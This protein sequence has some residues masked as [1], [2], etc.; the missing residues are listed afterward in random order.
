M[1]QRG[2]YNRG[3]RN[4]VAI[5]A[6]QFLIF[7]GVGTTV[8]WPALNYRWYNDDLHMIREFSHEELLLAWHHTWDFDG[9]ETIGYRPIEVLFNHTRARMFG[10]TMAALRLFIIALL[11]A[12][13]VVIARSA[14]RFGL[15]PAATTLAGVMTLCAKYNSYNLVWMADGVHVWQ[16]LTFALST[17]LRWVD[18]G[19]F[20]WMAAS[21]V[22]FVLG[23]LTH[24]GA[25]GVAP[26]L[27]VLAAVASLNSGKLAGQQKKLLG[28]AGVLAAVSLAALLARQS[29]LTAETDPP[30]TVP[31]YLAAQFV[32]I[33]TLAGWEPN[34]LVAVFLAIFAL[35]LLVAF[36]LTA[37][38]KQ[39]AMV[40][41][42][43]AR[44]SASPGIVETRVNLLLFPITFYCLFAAQV[45]VAYATGARRI[46]SLGR[47]IAVGT[48]II[49]VIVPLHYNRIQQLSMAPGA[50]G[51]VETDC[52]IA[53]GGDWA[54]A[55]AAKRRDD[56]L[57]ELGRLGLDAI[58]CATLID[59]SGHARVDRL[60]A[61]AFVPS[62]Q[63][64]AR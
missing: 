19:S 36:R 44:L 64:L 31:K 14:H 47:A 25:I 7:V 33:V 11:S 20:G 21:V 61:G 29:L 40:W 58:S 1:W 26:V 6:I 49:C 23:V 46:G 56:A 10:E 48:V 45:L 18:G 3:V 34:M 9:Y 35:L 54:K 2:L 55:A 4:G 62:S 50:V 30:W 15:T 38:E 27:I 57:R 13:L 22:C 59:A 24:E 41:L 17:V 16:G 5:A 32:E 12:S 39:T 60:P 28:Y 53:L 63:F 37:E 52:N 42:V 43:C 8:A 51:N